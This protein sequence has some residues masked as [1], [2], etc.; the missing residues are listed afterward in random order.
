MAKENI[1]ISTQEIVRTKVMCMR[2]PELQDQMRNRCFNK[3]KFSGFCKRHG[4][5][6]RQKAGGSDEY[7]I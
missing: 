6:N 3:K 1:V 7:S 5:K 2:S 4:F